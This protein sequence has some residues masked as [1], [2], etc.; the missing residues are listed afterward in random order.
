MEFDVFH[1]MAEWLKLVC[2]NFPFAFFS[3]LFFIQPVVRTIFKTVF[4]KDIQK[5]KEEAAKEEMKGKKLMPR[6]ESDTI[7]DLLK[8][9]EEI[10]AELK[11][12]I[13]DI[14]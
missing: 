2:Y 5:R 1:F 7:A 6:S 8:R 4:K 10:K 9:M 14:K 3:Q 13:E 11:Q 12:E